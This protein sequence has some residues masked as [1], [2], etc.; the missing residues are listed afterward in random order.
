MPGPPSTASAL[1]SRGVTLDSETAQTYSK[2]PWYAVRQNYCAAV[3]AAGGLPE[4]SAVQVLIRPEALHLTPVDDDRHGVFAEDFFQAE[5]GIRYQTPV[6]A[7]LL[8]RSSDLDH[9]RQRW[10][11]H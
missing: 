5:D 6:S 4:D 2:Y 1:L 7:F 9:Q 8:N 11:G 10:Y 3:V